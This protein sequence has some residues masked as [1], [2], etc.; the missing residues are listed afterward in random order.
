[1]TAKSDFLSLVTATTVIGSTKAFSAPNTTTEAVTC[2][3][4]GKATGYGPVRLT[5]SDTL[6]T[7]LATAT[8]Y[9]LIVVDANTVKFATTE[10]LALAGTAVN[11]TGA[12]AGTFAMQATMQTLADAIEDCLTEV[13]TSPGNRTTPAADNI[14]KAWAYATAAGF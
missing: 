1:M 9:W 13:L 10:A 7:G 11:L 8:N 2:T 3:A 4:H 14:S 5:T 12:G 6:P